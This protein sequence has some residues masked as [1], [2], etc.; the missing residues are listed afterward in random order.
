MTIDWWTLG[1][2]TVNVLVLVWLLARFFWRPVAAMIE[3]RRKAVQQTLAEAEAKRGEADA[4]LADIKRTRMSFDGERQAI[5]ASAEE[6]AEKLRHERVAQGEN[7]AAALRAAA[8]ATIDQGK[9]AADKAW[10]ERAGRLAIEIAQRLAAR[11]DGAAVQTAFL[12]WLIADIGKLPI[13]VREG[14]TA[15][16]VTLVLASAAPLSADDQARCGVRIGQA[17]NATVQLD[18]TADPA[19]IAGLE[20]RGPSIIMR[21]SWQADLSHILADIT[22]DSRS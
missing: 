10:T 13:A 5:L 17:L 7:E 12:D 3:E 11:L 4:A 1:L 22:N 20:L 18:F 9:K 14:L 19:L 2:Q 16:G 6:A 8:Q 15:P 21:N